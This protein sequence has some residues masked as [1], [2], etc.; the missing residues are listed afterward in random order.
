MAVIKEDNGDASSNSSTQYTISLG[1][2]FQGTLDPIRDRDW[3]RV[4]L[5]SGTIYAISPNGLGE[6]LRYQLFDSEGNEVQRPPNPFPSISIPHPGS[7]FIFEPPV[8]GTY[9]IQIY[10]VEFEGNPIDYEVSVDENTIPIGTY[11][12]IADYL[13]D[14]FW[15]HHGGNRRAF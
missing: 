13:T 1:D 6:W 15:E 7:K 10:A 4:E 5:T 8:S 11:D 12:D 14:G 2:V 3:I 9:Y